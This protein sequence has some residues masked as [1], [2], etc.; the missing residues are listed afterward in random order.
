MITLYFLLNGLIVGF[1]LGNFWKDSSFK[2]KDL[3]FI[4]VGVWIASPILLMISIYYVIVYNQLH[5]LILFH[6]SKKYNDLTLYDLHLKNKNVEDK[7]YKRNFVN[8]LNRMHNFIYL[9]QT[10]LR[11][12]YDYY[13]SDTNDENLPYTS[14]CNK[15]LSDYEF[16]DLIINKYG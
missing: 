12:I 16:R 14:F 2:F 5:E 10:V 8:K 13:I 11:D 15:M 6:F 3:L 9:N 7:L 1:F 4:F